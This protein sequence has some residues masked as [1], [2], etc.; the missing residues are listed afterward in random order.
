MVGRNYSDLMVWQKAMEFVVQLCRISTHF[1]KED[2]YGLT[3]QLRRAAVSVPANIAEGQGR[4]STREFRRFLLIASGSLCELETQ[5]L[6]GNRLGYLD[7]ACCAGLMD[8]IGEIGRLLN[9][10]L[11]SLRTKDG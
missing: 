8:E 9:G 6:I 4:H 11:R 10:L 7:K 3:G 5:V 1:P 2:L